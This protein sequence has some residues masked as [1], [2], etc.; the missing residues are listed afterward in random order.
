M[1]SEYE[2]MVQLAYDQGV[3]VIEFDFNGSMQGYYCDGYVFIDKY[4]NESQ[5]L[6]LLAEELGHHYTATQNITTLDTL[7]NRKQEAIGRQWAIEQ[8]LPIEDIIESVIGGC[9]NLYEVSEHL[10]LPMD[11]IS[12]A[13]SYYNR[14]KGERF[15]YADHL[16]ILSEGSIIV[17]PLP[18]VND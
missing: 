9:Y 14:K 16:V 13:L 11:F 3:Y 8:L 12:E 15:E 17:H 18:A 5:K 6:A 2:E 10:N 7:E 4:A 1:C